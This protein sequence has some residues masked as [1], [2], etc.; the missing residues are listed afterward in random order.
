MFLQGTD[1]IWV[2]GGGEGPY[3]R[4]CY[5]GRVHVEMWD[6]V[7]EELTICFICS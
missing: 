4:V 7:K 6:P 1:E 2:W 5:A 3:E